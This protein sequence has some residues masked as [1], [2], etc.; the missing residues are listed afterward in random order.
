LETGKSKVLLAVRV[1]DG[2]TAAPARSK[3][4]LWPFWVSNSNS[5]Q[6]WPKVTIT[7]GL[8]SILIQMQL[9]KI[10]YFI[11]KASRLKV[12]LSKTHVL[13]AVWFVWLSELIIFSTNNSDWN[14]WNVQL[15]FITLFWNLLKVLEAPCWSL[16]PR[17]VTVPPWNALGP[18]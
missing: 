1:M 11:K 9:L 10:S 13:P 16:R 14:H 12:K 5:Q 8:A 15:R 17:R 3:E 18:L 6:S 2:I 4:V 7:T